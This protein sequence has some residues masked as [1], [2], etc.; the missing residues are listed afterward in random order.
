MKH[1]KIHGSKSL[2]LVQQPI[3]WVFYIYISHL[4]HSHDLP[5]SWYH[6]INVIE[7]IYNINYKSGQVPELK[8]ILTAFTV[9]NFR[10]PQVFGGL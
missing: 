3:W 9:T 6:K 10:Y 2:G 1:I 7:F 5:E 8:I 4:N